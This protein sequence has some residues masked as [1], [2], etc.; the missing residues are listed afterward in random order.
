MAGRQRSDEGIQTNMLHFK[1]CPKC[2][3]GTVEHNDD[4][5]GEYAQCLNCGFMRDVPSGISDPRLGKLLTSWRKELSSSE[6]QS[7]DAVA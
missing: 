3:T 2:V 4:A 7:A 6:H 5:H 1:S